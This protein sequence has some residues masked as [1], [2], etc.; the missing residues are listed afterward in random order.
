M[1][2]HHSLLKKTYL[3]SLKSD[4]SKLDINKLEKVLSDLISQGNKVD[5]F[6]VDSLKAVP[7]G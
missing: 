1:L 2:V 5:K 3:V 6:D 4:I 7:V